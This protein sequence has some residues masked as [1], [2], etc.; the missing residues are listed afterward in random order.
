MVN[1]V[2]CV[3]EQVATHMLSDASWIAK[4]LEASREA[5]VQHY[6]LLAE[7]LEKLKIPFVR[8]NAALF[9]WADFSEFG[10]DL[11]GSQPLFEELLNDYA[12]ML[13]P[14]VACYDDP[15]LIPRAADAASKDRCW[16]RMCYA[17]V[18]TEALRHGL[19]QLE[20]FANDRR[21]QGEN[22]KANARTH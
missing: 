7:C 22:G 5:V 17:A 21:L 6:G 16:M 4:H 19:T 2:G 1:S 14:G 10:T 3:T 9:L 18:R 20:K 13:T 12:L 11:A 15:S 8:P